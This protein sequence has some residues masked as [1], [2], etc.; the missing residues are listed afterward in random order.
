MCVQ[1]YAYDH[2]R[3]CGDSCSDHDYTL[4]YD[5]CDEEDIYYRCT[6]CGCIRSEENKP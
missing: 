1:C 6:R 5:M 4:Y 2:S 3:N